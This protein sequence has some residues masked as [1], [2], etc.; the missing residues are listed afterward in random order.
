M[1]QNQFVTKN[2][3]VNQS[4]NDSQEPS[5]SDNSNMN[6]ESSKSGIANSSIDSTHVDNQGGFYFLNLTQLCGAANDNILKQILI[7]GLAQGQ[8]WSDA[9]GKGAQ[10]WASICLAVPFILFSG[11]AGQFSDK[12]SK[13]DVAVL[14]KLSEVVIALIAAVGLWMFNLWLVLFAMVLISMQSVFFSPAKFGILPEI[15]EKKNLSRANGTINMFTYVAIIFGGAVGGPIYDAYA[16]TGANA[17]PMPWLPGLIILIV[18]T[19]GTAAA[20]GLPRLIAKNRS[21]KINYRLFEGYIKTWKSIHGTALASVIVAWSFFYLIVAGV[22]ILIIPDYQG[23]MNISAT[24]T[25]IMMALL[26]ISIGVGDFIAG[27]ISS[28]GIRTELIP[29]GTLFATIVFAILP[30]LPISGSYSGIAKDANGNTLKNVEVSI[31]KQEKQKIQIDLD[32]ENAEPEMEQ[33]IPEGPVVATTTTDESGKYSFEDLD[34][35]DYWT[36]ASSGKISEPKIRVYG[37]TFLTTLFLSMAGFVAGFVMVPLQTMTQRLSSNSN[38]GQVLGLWSCGSFVGIVIGNLGFLVIKNLGM[39]SN[40]AFL[41]CAGLGVVFLLTYQFR[42]K[43]IFDRELKQIN[44]SSSA[45][46]E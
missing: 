15:I 42:W 20:F 18:A 10:A 39:P 16:A 9:L 3:I 29:W 21:M 43:A 34:P 4:Q 38:R 2:V 44:D 30:F 6:Q 46:A 25:S 14:S 17:K 22:A 40:L 28:H 13:R 1:N 26:G 7:L 12:F 33:P 19:I 35:A 31:V 27:R 41:I 37:S 11:F 8:I 23:L 36:I 24:Q 45:D 5:D 32:G